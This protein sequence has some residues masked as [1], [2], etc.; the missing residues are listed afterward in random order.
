MD[1]TFTQ[2]TRE[3]LDT[4]VRDST[5]EPISEFDYDAEIEDSLF[6]LFTSHILE[7]IE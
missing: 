6:N 4:I 2:M 7:G 5:D 3:E 1:Q